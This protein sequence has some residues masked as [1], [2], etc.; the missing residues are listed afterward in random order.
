[1]IINEPNLLLV[2]ES[3]VADPSEIIDEYYEILL[4]YFKGEEKFL[5]TML[6]SL[7]NSASF[8]AIKG[9]IITSIQK[10]MAALK[11]VSEVEE[12]SFEEYDDTE[13]E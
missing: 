5:E 13:D 7:Y 4:P 1:M 10:Q 2:D 12:E 3:D 9:Y 6:I 8:N 11:E